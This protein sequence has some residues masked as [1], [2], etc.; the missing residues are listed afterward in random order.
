MKPL[1]STS[2]PKGQNLNTSYHLLNDLFNS[3]S[4]SPQSLSAFEDPILKNSRPS[5]YYINQARASYLLSQK[6]I[7]KPRIKEDPISKILAK[8]QHNLNLMRKELNDIVPD[9]LISRV[10]FQ[11]YYQRTKLLEKIDLM[12]IVLSSPHLRT[13]SE[14]RSL[15]Q[16]I[17]SIE[18]FKNLPKT[19][20]REIC[21]RLNTI[22]Y[23][24]GEKSNF[25][26]VIK[27]GATPDFVFIIYSGSVGI[28]LNSVKIAQND[29][30]G[31]FGDIALDKSSSRTADAIAET[32][33]ILFTIKA[34]DYKNIVFNYK[35]LE[36]H[37]NCK[38][39]Q[40]IPFFS[41]WNFTKVQ[42][43]SNNLVPCIFKSGEVI[44]EFGEQSLVFYLVNRGKVEIQTFIV[45]KEKNRW[46]V[47][48]HSWNIKK[49][50]SEYVYPITTAG[51]GE[52]FG[53][54]E[55]LR[56]GKRETRAI[57]LETTL[58]LSLNEDEFNS[59]F[60]PK[61]KEKLLKENK[62][63]IPTHGGMEKSLR[64]KI[65]NQYENEKV[66]FD[67]MQIA[68]LPVDKDSINDKRSQKLK[69]WMES[70]RLRKKF[71][72][73]VIKSRIIKN[74]TKNKIKRGFTLHHLGSRTE[75]ER[76]TSETPSSLSKILLDGNRSGFNTPTL[77]ANKS[78][79]KNIRFEDQKII[80][81]RGISERKKKGNVQIGFR[82]KSENAKE[83]IKNAIK[84]AIQPKSSMKLLSI[85]RSPTNTQLV[86]LSATAKSGTHTPIKKL[87][88]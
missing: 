60:N 11:K 47:G 78:E 68:Y 32:D 25:H 80:K 7:K 23:K 18:Y 26:I 67:A 73:E 40:S 57:A 62:V 17:C 83:T 4:Q 24:A 81:E 82:N 20:I 71:E 56:K 30:G 22:A 6:S 84:N 45:L 75:R 66:L 53:E 54:F 70:I 5:D 9:W 74:T 48:I 50:T 49:V 39:I 1:E 64:K 76:C 79:K 41:N 8:P 16:W 27:K 37:E 2:T 21:E 86:H 63:C 34:Q 31:Y 61:E 35:T 65:R 13:E 77:F 36:K 85:P 10:D 58:C 51:T 29:E 15:F 19:I 87:N 59:S 3:V 33:V 14:K 69:K 44:Y 52:F 46:P 42:L 28:Y 55:L 72:K 38:F 12:K 88:K 43:L